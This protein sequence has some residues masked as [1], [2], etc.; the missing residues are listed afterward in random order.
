LKILKQS[1]A[2]ATGLMPEVTSIDEMKP[3]DKVYLVLADIDEA[4]LMNMEALRFNTI[5]ILASGVKGVLRV[6]RGRAFDCEAP[7]RSLHSRLLR[8]L[9]DES[10]IHRYV[11]LDLD[12]KSPPWTPTGTTAILDVFKTTFN[13]DVD[14]G[15]IDFEYAERRSVIHVPRFSNDPVENDSISDTVV[16]TPETLPYH[17]PG[18]ELKLGVEQ[19]GPLDSLRFRD[20]PNASVPL[21]DDY[22]EIESKAFGLN[23]RDIMVGTGP[24]QE[25]NMGFE[26][27]GVITRVGADTSHGFEVGDRVCALISRGGWTTYTWLHWTGVAKIPDSTSFEAAVSIPMVF[28]TAYY[29]FFEVARLCKGESVLIHAGSG[30]VG[31]AAIMLANHIDAE[32]FTTVSTEDKEQFLVDT[33][34]I[35]PDHNLSSRVPSF[36]KGIMS[37]TSG[38]GVDVVQ[39]SL[40]GQMLQES[41]NCV[42]YLGRFVEISKRDIQANKYLQMENFQEA[43]SFA[44]IDL[45]QLATYKRS[46]QA[47]VM[48]QVSQLMAQGNIRTIK[49]ITV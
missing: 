48:E 16:S 27:S 33:Y 17:Q 44:S 1:L 38:R 25:K 29:C 22:M 26:A 28:A 9:R 36:S 45:I 40:S 35:I 42:T 24:M 6:S 19:P 11:T 20:D 3:T 47:K 4:C 10:R 41:W 12:P 23:F 18:R 30:G 21:P 7:E 31:Q 14:M 32:I 39:N 5:R 13:Y 8:T 34:G 37:A 15:P 43:I 49:P 46:A 2:E